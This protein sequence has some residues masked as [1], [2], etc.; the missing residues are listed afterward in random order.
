LAFQRGEENEDALVGGMMWAE[1]HRFV[2]TW[3]VA[4]DDWVRAW[5]KTKKKRR[6]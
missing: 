2:L 6:R 1:L 3:G 5:I 4:W